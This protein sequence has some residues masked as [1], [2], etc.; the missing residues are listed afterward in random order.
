MEPS[1]RRIQEILADFEARGVHGVRAALGQE[2]FGSALKIQMAEAWL[3]KQKR[4]HAEGEVLEEG[5]QHAAQAAA[6]VR[7]AT[8]TPERDRL[9]R[10]AIRRANVANAVAAGAFLL[11]AIA[12]AR[13]MGWL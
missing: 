1:D 5:K 10:K 12:L 11:A 6:L 3:E 9:A 8:E 2:I 13:S 4:G 7:Q